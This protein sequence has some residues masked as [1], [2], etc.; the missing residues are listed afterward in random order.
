MGGSPKKF[1]ENHAFHFGYNG[2]QRHSLHNKSIGKHEIVAILEIKENMFVVCRQYML[3]QK[4]V[5]YWSY[6]LMFSKHKVSHSILKSL[7]I[8]T[9]N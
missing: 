8:L 4:E 6:M 5:I 3:Y 1:F 9:T 7:H 2:D